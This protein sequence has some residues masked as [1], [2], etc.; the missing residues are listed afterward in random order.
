MSARGI[1]IV[2]AGPAGLATARSYREHGGDEEVILLGR[3]SLI[4]Y[5]RPPLTKEFLRG[6]R[7]PTNC[8]SSRRPGSGSTMSSCASDARSAPSIPESAA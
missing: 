7:T 1:V 5:R 2:G 3:E 6:E 4:P 8:R